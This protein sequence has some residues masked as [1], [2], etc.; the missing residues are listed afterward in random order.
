MTPPRAAAAPI[1][2]VLVRVA[3]AV[4][5]PLGK[6]IFVREGTSF[7]KWHRLQPSYLLAEVLLD[8]WVFF[9]Q[10]NTRCLACFTCRRSGLQPVCLPPLAF[11]CRSHNRWPMSVHVLC[12]LMPHVTLTRHTH[13]LSAL[14][15]I[16]KSE[17]GMQEY[18]MG[19]R[20]V[21]MRRLRAKILS[22]SPW[23]SIRRKVHKPRACSSSTRG[24]AQ[25][26]SILSASVLLP[27]ITDTDMR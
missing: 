27:H 6:S 23:Q 8:A 18:K 26:H 9:W 12:Q 4:W 21:E 15:T 2:T 22:C 20:T 25:F 7:L 17:I 11:C 13:S 1:K 19:Q 16:I 3:A 10:H 24:F 14:H 5:G